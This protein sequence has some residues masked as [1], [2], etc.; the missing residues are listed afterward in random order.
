MGRPRACHSGWSADSTVQAWL[1]Q[2]GWGVREGG[3][4]AAPPTL[5]MV[6]RGVFSASRPQSSEE[7]DAC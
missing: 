3:L 7:G 6:P 2:A 4:G 5:H 1:L